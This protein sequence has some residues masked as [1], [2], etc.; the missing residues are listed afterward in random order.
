MIILTDAD[1][2]LEDLTQVWIELLNE[3]YGRNVKYEDVVEWDMCK[4]YPGLTRDQVYGMELQPE[5]YDRMR[6]LE[7]AR[8]VLEKIIAK[9]HELYVV[10]NTPYEVFTDKMEKV[11]FKYYPFLTWD[12]FIVTSNKKLIK[13]DVLIDDG[14]HNLIEGDYK[15]IL[16]SAPYNEEFDAESHGMIR[17]RNW[18]DI[19]EALISLGVL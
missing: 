7:G 19:E 9:G 16:V 3:T 10:T 6:P 11:M 18:K 1:G 15:K 2:V 13:G 12:H 17:V 4:A 14:V 8:E 5:I